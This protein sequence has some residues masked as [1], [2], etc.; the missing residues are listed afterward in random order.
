MRRGKS[1][2]FF[3]YKKFFVVYNQYQR[4]DQWDLSEVRTERMCGIFVDRHFIICRIYSNTVN[5]SCKSFRWNSFYSRYGNSYQTGITEGTASTKIYWGIA[6]FFLFR[7]TSKPNGT[8]PKNC[9][10]NRIPSTNGFYLGWTYWS[11]L[12][13]CWWQKRQGQ[14]FLSR[15][16]YLLS[17]PDH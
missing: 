4:A 13:R 10:V 14:K 8:T 9:Y 1:K 5:N 12:L 15:V 7:Q 16:N 11:L 3:I 6:R 2:C 17:H